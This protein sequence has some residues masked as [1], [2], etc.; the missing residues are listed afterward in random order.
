[1]LSPFAYTSS[2]DL[3]WVSDSSYHLTCVPLVPVLSGSTIP[4]CRPSGRN[5]MFFFHISEAFLV[6]F[7]FFVRCLFSQERTSSWSVW[8][9]STRFIIWALSKNSHEFVIFSM[10]FLRAIRERMVHSAR[11]S[12]CR[13]RLSI[14]RGHPVSHR[15][16]RRHF[17][18]GAIHSFGKDVRLC[19]WKQNNK[20]G[21]RRRHAGGG[22][23][24]GWQSRSREM[25]LNGSGN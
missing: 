24:K 21:R 17:L 11:F 9:F 2:G 3:T 5:W 23:V 12:L 10:F 13:S 8:P 22:E 16:R 1:M 15:L 7:P 18:P 6:C 19:F 20:W 14:L 25:K 4:P